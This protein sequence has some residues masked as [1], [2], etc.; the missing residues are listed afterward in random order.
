[1]DAGDVVGARRPD[2]L[3]AQQVGGG[4]TT[5]PR[6]TAHGDHGHRGL[7]KVCGQ[8]GKKRQQC[9]GRIAAGHRDAAGAAQLVPRARQLGQP[10]RPATGVRRPVEPLPDGGVGEPK[11]RPQSMI[12]V[13]GLSCCANT[14]ECPCG[15]A[16][17]T[18]SWPPS[19]AASV[20][21]TT[22][23]A[24]G[25]RCGWCSPS[26]LPA[27]VAAVSAPILSRPSAYA[28]CPSSRRRISPPA[29]PLA[30][31]T[32]TFVALATCRFC[33]V[34]QQFANSFRGDCAGT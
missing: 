8:R 3:R 31:A 28:G 29:Y 25:V 6:G 2:D 27:L 11:V 17:K 32:A 1:M 30:P 10:I 34:M 14:A 20:G 33:I 4:R 19:T 7:D 9:R 18:A 15:K 22:R 16:K 13:S 5:R 12:S 26:V 23:W 24:S 21:S